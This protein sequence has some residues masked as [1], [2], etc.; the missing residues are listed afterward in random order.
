MRNR[1]A[2]ENIWIRDGEQWD[3]VIRLPAWEASFSGEPGLHGLV[4]VD[5]TEDESAV[6]AKYAPAL[7]YLREHQK[8]LR[9]AMLPELAR[10]Q[11]ETNA[12]VLQTF[13]DHPVQMALMPYMKDAE[14]Q[15]RKT[16]TV[17]DARAMFTLGSVY[18]LPLRKDGM[19]YIGF[20]FES[21]MDPEHGLG[22]MMH[23]DR[24]VEV[25]IEAA[26]YFGN[27]Q[28][29]AADRDGGEPF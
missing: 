18:L 29:S 10:T 28:H 26:Y 5:A 8:I 21:E 16:V 4:V 2:D 22:V 25:G 13:R 20:H 1:N 3:S 27:Y 14:K 23:G 15:L 17:D 24:V 7:A 12:L 9:E 19:P 11:N 6:R